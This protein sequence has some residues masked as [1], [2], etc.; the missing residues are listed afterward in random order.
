[1]PFPERAVLDACVLYPPSLRDVLLTLAALDAFDV[2]WG[3][4]ILLEVERNVLADH[5]DID[6]DRFRS[7]TIAAMR[8]A[9]PNALTRAGPIDDAALAAVHPNDRHVVAL[10]IG[11]HTDTI[12]TINVRHFPAT[13]LAPLG[14]AVLTPGTL[15]A[16][17]DA[18]EPVLVDRA[19]D[20][21]ARRW[22]RPPR[23]VDEILD[24]LAVHPTMSRAVAAIGKRR[25]RT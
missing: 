21:L 19:L 4:S 6:P 2:V 11:G 18:T 7:H 3:E 8:R 16:G 10:A 23:S 22:T 15:L 14:I 9:F 13:S 25:R 5:P 12:V 17:L 20:H 1:V 24:L